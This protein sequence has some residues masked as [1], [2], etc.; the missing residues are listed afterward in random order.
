MVAWILPFFRCGL[1]C[2]LLPLVVGI[3][4]AVDD[5]MMTVMI[6]L[7]MLPVPL[8]H[9]NPSSMTAHQFLSHSLIDAYF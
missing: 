3:P 2:F 7:M 6:M 9:N 1:A 4:A 8:S 5:A